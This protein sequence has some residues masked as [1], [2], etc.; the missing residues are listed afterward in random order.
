VQISR[1]KARA[2]LVQQSFKY[3]DRV[4]CD[5]IAPMA[6]VDACLRA[7]ATPY[8]ACEAV[9]RTL[10]KVLKHIATGCWLK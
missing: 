4:D 5:T 6:L 2:S 10:E 7:A 1:T 9:S 3:A 8:E